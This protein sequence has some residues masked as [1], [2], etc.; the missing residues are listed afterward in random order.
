MYAS[1]ALILLKQIDQS[2]RKK[3]GSMFDRQLKGAN[4]V[5]TCGAKVILQK[6]TGGT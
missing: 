5:M 6:A 4:R 1:G 2:F 3:N